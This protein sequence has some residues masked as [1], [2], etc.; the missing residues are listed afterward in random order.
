MSAGILSD[1]IDDVMAS[2]LL[3]NIESAVGK[4][5]DIIMKV[6][7]TSNLPASK[8]IRR[9]LRSVVSDK[10]ES[11]A[12]ANKNVVTS[13]EIQTDNAIIMG[14]DYL[15][16]LLD[17]LLENAIE[18]NPRKNKFVWVR[19]SDDV[20]GYR[21]SIADNGPGIPEDRIKSLFDM[22]T[23]YGGI[24]LHQS[25]HIAEKLGGTIEVHERVEGDFT[26]GTVV[27]VFIPSIK[28]MEPLSIA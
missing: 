6:K 3:D 26:K 27:E 4:C 23:R 20:G 9:S 15:E 28:E 10:C 21:L 7:T 14:N 19:L 11:F 2:G 24:G 1:V 17:N 12:D 13:I 25:K 5:I 8:L 18:H 22:T 16:S